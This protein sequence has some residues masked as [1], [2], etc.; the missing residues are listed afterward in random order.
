MKSDCC[1]MVVVCSAEKGAQIGTQC[2]QATGSHPCLATELRA[3]SSELRAQRVPSVPHAGRLQ[4][5]IAL[6]KSHL[7]VPTKCVQG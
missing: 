2:T 4:A 5:G 3:Q 7:S 6:S 1:E